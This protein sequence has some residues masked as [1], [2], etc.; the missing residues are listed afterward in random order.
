MKISK[1][2]S[3]QAE[4][5][6]PIFFSDGLNVILGEIRLP[7][8]RKKDTHNIGKTTIGRLINFCLLSKKSNE[9]FLFK[10]PEHFKNFIFFIEVQLSDGSYVTIRRSVEKSSKINLKKHQGRNQDFTFI[11]ESDWT[12]TDLPF[13]KAKEILDG[14]LNLLSIKPWDFRMELGYLLR[15]QDDYHDIFI[16]GNFKGSHSKW[17]PFLAHIFG[18]E[19]SC[20]KQY[21]AKEDELTN[22]ETSLKVIKNEFNFSLQDGGKIES[23]LLLKQEELQKKQLFLDSFDFGSEDEVKTSKLV[24]HID[25]KISELNK[26]RYS[27]SLNLKKIITSLEE[28]QISFSPNKAESLFKEVGIFFQ[29]QIKKNYEQLIK[30]NQEITKERR[31]YLIQEKIETENIIEK[32]NKELSD[33]GKK[34]SEILSFLSDTDS[35]IKYKK[36]SNELL[37]LKTDIGL[38]EHKREQFRRIQETQAKIRTINEQKSTLQAKIESDLMR[39]NSDK[40]SLLSKI[41]LYFNEIVEEVIDRKAILNISLNKENHLDFKAEILDENG[42]ITSAIDGHT[43]KKLLCIA[44]DLA[45][46]RAYVKEKFPKFVFHDGVFESLDDRKKLNLMKVIRHYSDMGIQQIITLIDSDLTDKDMN[47]SLILDDEIVLRL[48]DEGENGRLFKMQ[49]W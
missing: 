23:I 32:I 19:T 26:K 28:E 8:N 24:D 43:Y 5:F 44:F 39:K 48:H 36:F 4:K 37:Y 38:L 22:L 14:Y 16:L 3:N 31:E 49:G 13:E 10:H 47:E 9:F 20:I 30:F 41:R 42:G 6:E 15:S 34:R 27:L 35:F 18:L 45:I 2:Y 1:I 12:Y 7:E 11:Y 40:N 46:L 17:K 33:L 25:E 29:G 21:Y